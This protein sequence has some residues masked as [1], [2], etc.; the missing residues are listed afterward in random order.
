MAVTIGQYE[1]TLDPKNRLV[2][3]PRYCDA[4]LA[5]KGSHFILSTG[6]DGCVWL[7]LPSQWE[8]AQAGMKDTTREVKNKEEVRKSYRKLFGSAIEAALDDQ[9]R[10][11]VAQHLKEHAGL[12]K[13]VMIVGVGSKA[14]IWDRSRWNTSMK[15][16]AAASFERLSKDLDI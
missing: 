11:L 2:I 3:P 8:R 12:K 14:E 7:F 13:D 5:E 10:V 9:G 16:Q 4:L 1:Y 15:K 6:L